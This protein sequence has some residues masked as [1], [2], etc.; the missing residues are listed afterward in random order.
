MAALRASTAASPAEV[1]WQIEE[2]VD[3]GGAAGKTSL[4]WELGIPGGED[5][6]ITA[7]VSQDNVVSAVHAYGADGYR[8]LPAAPKPVLC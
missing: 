3:S 5:F 4:L 1:R 8:G 2:V 6:Q 7:S